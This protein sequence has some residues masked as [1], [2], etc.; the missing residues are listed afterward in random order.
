MLRVQAFTTRGNLKVHMGTHM[1]HNSPSRRGRRMTIDSSPFLFANN[2]YLAAAAGFHPGP[3]RPP[4]PPEAFFQYQNLMNGMAPPRSNEIPVI[5]S[6]NG[7]IG[8]HLPPMYPG[9]PAHLFPTHPAGEDAVKHPADLSLA[10]S[11]S[12]SGVGERGRGRDADR[13]TPPPPKRPR[14]T[15]PSSPPRPAACLPNGS[16]DLAGTVTS[17]GELDLSM[18]SSSAPHCSPPKSSPKHAYPPS[19]ARAPSSPPRAP[20]S[21]DRAVAGT[22]PPPPPPTHAKEIAQENLLSSP[23]PSWM[24]SASSCHHC[25]QSFPSTSALEQHIQSQHLKNDSHPSGQKAITA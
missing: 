10:R 3:P 1:Y 11:H 6:V 4:P 13:D 20:P 5:Q 25:G 24:W 17:T 19:P 22:P 18:K 15:S 12:A 23:K 16:A 7:G 14:V 21:G 8:H 2:P 9:F